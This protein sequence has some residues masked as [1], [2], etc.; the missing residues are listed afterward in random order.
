MSVLSKEMLLKFV[1]AQ[2]IVSRY[3]LK[4]AEM[5]YS[6]QVEDQRQVLKGLIALRDIVAT[7]AEDEGHFVPFSEFCVEDVIATADR[8]KKITNIQ[9]FIPQFWQR[10]FAS[11]LI[12]PEREPMIWRH[13]LDAHT[14]YRKRVSLTAQEW[15][16]YECSALQINALES[17][18]G[19]TETTMSDIIRKILDQKQLN[20][21]DIQYIK[22][23]VLELQSRT[24]ANIE[25]NSVVANSMAEK[26]GFECDQRSLA[27]IASMPFAMKDALR[28]AGK[29]AWSELWTTYMDRIYD[30]PHVIMRILIADEGGFFLGGTNPVTANWI[31]W[32][33]SQGTMPLPIF[34]LPVSSHMCLEFKNEPDWTQDMVNKHYRRPRN[35]Y[36]ACPYDKV[37]LINYFTCAHNNIILA[38][39]PITHL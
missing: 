2:V 9:H 12:I 13:D 23:F 26:Y 10:N 34:W 7:T 4:N 15:H 31:F 35:Y 24:P 39:H 6:A 5:L 29:D 32:R 37:R 18:F 3:M 36:V 16:L 19:G 38:K 30:M 22:Q 33:Y 17:Y 14:K 8:I 27:I 21:R 11:E 20:G 1:D 25:I 28:Q